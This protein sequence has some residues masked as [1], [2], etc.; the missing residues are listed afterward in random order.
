MEQGEALQY[1]IWKGKYVIDKRGQDLKK[2]NKKKTTHYTETQIR[3]IQ[4]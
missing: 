4:A 3:M 1:Q 2:Q